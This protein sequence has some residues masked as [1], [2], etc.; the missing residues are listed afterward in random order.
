MRTSIFFIIAIIAAAAYAQNSTASTPLVTV[1]SVD[2]E[3][4]IGTYYN[5]ASLPFIFETFCHCGYVNYTWVNETAELLSLA[6]TC[7]FFTINGPVVTS[8]SDAYPVDST[9][10][11]LINSNFYGLAKADYWFID[12]DEQYKWFAIGEPTRTYFWILAKGPLSNETY[13]NIIDSAVN[14]GYNLDKLE[15]VDAGCWTKTGTSS[16]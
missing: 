5:V 7:N 11:K 10:S 13:T 6:E 8:D 2:L 4:I 14:N 1:P 12:L 9:N 3:R 16:F 15:Y